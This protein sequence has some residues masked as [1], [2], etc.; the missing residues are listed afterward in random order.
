MLTRA[1]QRRFGKGETL[2]RAGDPARGLFVIL[3]GAVRVVRSGT[4]GG[5]QHVIHTEEA[6]GT[7]GEVPIFDGGGYPATAIATTDTHC[8]VFS[9]GGI[10]AAMEA[11]P[12]VG[13]VIV[14][15]LAARVRR[16][17][18]RL[19]QQVSH[20][21]Q[22]RLAAYLLSLESDGDEVTLPMTQAELAEHLGSVREVI[23][24]DL[25]RLK[26]AGAIESAGRGRVRLVDRAALERLAG[27]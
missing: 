10:R 7:L 15:R 25:R 3:S 14:Q 21:T 5:R 8:L 1:T 27:G 9:P 6:G 18:D 12:Q 11:D 2:F 22:A 20:S 26:D 17:V 19:D 4:G 24:R 16:L 13:W 23:V